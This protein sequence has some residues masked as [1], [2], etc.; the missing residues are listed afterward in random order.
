MP[1]SLKDRLQLYSCRLKAITATWSSEET[2]DNDGSLERSS[3]WK[4]RLEDDLWIITYNEQVYWAPSKAWE[5]GLTIETGYR[6]SEKV[7]ESELKPIIYELLEPAKA[8]ASFLVAF[9]T[10]QMWLLPL[11]LP[12]LEEGNGKK[13]RRRKSRKEETKRET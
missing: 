5:I 11:V 6:M 1:K 3:S 8:V 12:P 4:S 10:Q 9:V 7:S 13:K 2:F